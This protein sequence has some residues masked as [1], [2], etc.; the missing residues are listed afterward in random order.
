ME[1]NHDTTDTIITS[2]ELEVIR[3]RVWNTMQQFKN[4]SLLFPGTPYYRWAKLYEALAEHA[5]SAY[6]A[7]HD[8]F[9][10]WFAH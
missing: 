8:I 1:S 5:R 9:D 7:T 3:Q 10:C 4:Q 6:C 2:L